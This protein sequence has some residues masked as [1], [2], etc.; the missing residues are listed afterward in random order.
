MPRR[1]S[2]VA[3]VARKR[4]SM[5]L[6]ALLML[7]AAAGIAGCEPYLDRVAERNCNPT[8]DGYEGCIYDRSAL[9]DRRLWPTP[10]IGRK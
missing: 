6:L 10:E 8:A 2:L 4:A 5:T 7:L 1:I 9:E 3:A